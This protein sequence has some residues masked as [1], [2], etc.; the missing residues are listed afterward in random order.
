MN[1]KGG[2]VNDGT[3]ILHAVVSD[4]EA[5]VFQHGYIDS[6]LSRDEFSK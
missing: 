4:Q 6:Q 3:E 5:Q 1:L 2:M